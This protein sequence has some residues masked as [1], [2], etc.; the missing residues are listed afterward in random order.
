[1]NLNACREFKEISLHVDDEALVGKGNIER[2]MV[3]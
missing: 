2:K 1:M 3:E